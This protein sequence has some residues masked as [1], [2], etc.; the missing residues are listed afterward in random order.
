MPIASGNLRVGIVR[1][2]RGPV[3]D[4]EHPIYGADGS[5]TGDSTTAL[6]AALDYAAT[7]SGGCVHLRAGR[8]FACSQISVPA[9]VTL[10]CDGAT[11]I[12]SAYAG[13]S[14]GMV[15]LQAGSRVTGVLRIDGNAAS[16]TGVG[17]TDSHYAVEVQGDNVLIEAADIS[18][19]TTG[20]CYHIQVTNA[21]FCRV[22]ELRSTSASY[23]AIRLTSNTGT[24]KLFEVGDV[25]AINPAFKGFVFNGRGGNAVDVDGLAVETIWFRRFW[26]DT[27]TTQDASNGFQIDSGDSDPGVTATSTVIRVGRLHVGEMFCRGFRSDGAKIQHTRYASIGTMFSQ[28]SSALSGRAALRAWCPNM[29]IGSIECTERIIAYGNIRIDELNYIGSGDRAIEIFG[30]L[31]ERAWIGDLRIGNSTIS[32]SPIRVSRGTNRLVHL[33]AYDST[34]QSPL[35]VSSPAPDNQIFF[36]VGPGVLRAHANNTITNSTD[37]DR[38]HRPPRQVRRTAAPTT[39]TWDVPDICWNTTPSATGYVG[40]VCVTAGTPG[41]WKGFGQIEA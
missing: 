22:R 8:S 1:Q 41:T 38:V 10:W 16:V 24:L 30:M 19:F 5:G 28:P 26:C 3:V 33:E 20:Y 4:P 11:L 14:Q 18:G 40:W 21:D 9:G 17:S 2:G 27:N 31:G 39:G 29:K 35:A 34:S 32:S 12:R 36:S 7:Q 37:N 15:R 25:V 13:A 6:Q 23:A